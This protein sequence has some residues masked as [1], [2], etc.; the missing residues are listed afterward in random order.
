MTPKT[1]LI[2][3]S[4]S[5]IKLIWPASSVILFSAYRCGGSRQNDLFKKNSKIQYESPTIYEQRYTTQTK[6]DPSPVSEQPSNDAPEQNLS[7]RENTSENQQSIQ[8]TDIATTL[9]QDSVGS[10]VAGGDSVFDQIRRGEYKLKPI[11]QIEKQIP[12]K[13]STP[14]DL[15]MAILDA[16][17]KRNFAVQGSDDEDSSDDDSDWEG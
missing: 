2:G 3:K 4:T 16:I 1:K 7:N 12:I 14:N 15:S 8:Q 6:E 10:E 5:Y 17:R 13:Q 11:A 9:K